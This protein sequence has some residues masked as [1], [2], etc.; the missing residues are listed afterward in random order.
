MLT[1]SELL[2]YADVRNRKLSVKDF[3][4]SVEIQHLDGSKFFVK[5]AHVEKIGQA[6]IIVYGEH[7]T[8]MV[9]YVEDIKYTI[10]ER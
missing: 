3:S 8:P 1:S 5:F 7:Q 6:N 2:K 9:F 4:Q 10:N